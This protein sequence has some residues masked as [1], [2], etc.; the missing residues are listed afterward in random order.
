MNGRIYVILCALVACHAPGRDLKKF[1]YDCEKWPEGAPPAEVFVVDGTIRI[2]QK[3]GGKAIEIGIDPLVDGCALLGSSANGSASIQA[4][5]F[6]SKSG[7]SYPR[8]GIGI[9]GQSGYRLIV[10]CAK[11]ELHLVKNEQVIKSAPYEWT[12]DDW[13]NLKLEALEDAQGKW[14][15]SGKAWPA[16]AAEPQEPQIKHQDPTLKGQGKC[17][18]WGTPF[19]GTPIYFDDVHL[20]IEG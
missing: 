10:L 17:S 3:T 18:I 11:K 14:S 16:G 9:H 5:V 15:I 20:E 1:S 12:S 13:M 8:F 7:R 4:R 6:A 2:T 19:S